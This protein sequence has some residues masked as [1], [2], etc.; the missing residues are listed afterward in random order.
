M[1]KGATAQRVVFAKEVTSS[2]QPRDDELSV[3]I[4]FARHAARCNICVD[5]YDAYK[6]DIPL[7]DR[8]HSFARD[9]AKYIYAKGGKPFSVVDRQNGDRIQIEIPV[10]CE[11]ITDLVKA[12]DRGMNLKASKP[13]VVMSKGEKRE[14]V[15]RFE[16]IERVD[17][18]PSHST[19]PKE[20][21]VYRQDDYKIVEIVP[22]STRRE[23][24]ER[25]GRGDRVEERYR[26][27]RKERPVSYVE[28]KGSLYE[29]D[30]EEKRRRQRY[31]E[32]PIV[33]VA[34]P[35]QRYT[36]R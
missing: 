9:V 23:R 31:E 25:D 21:P 30:E 4:Y 8:G 5:P 14:K 26:Y 19:R 16:K 24:K 12:F 10:G 35:R 3:M 34:E 28:R 18:S 17:R 13:V 11:V 20:Y 7:C 1:A 15:E 32:Q 36:R 27:E 29:R 6:R 22:N 33:I 2:R